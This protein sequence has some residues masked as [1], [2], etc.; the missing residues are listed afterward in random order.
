MP[1][2]VHWSAGSAS[3]VP[4]SFGKKAPPLCKSDCVSQLHGSEW[5]T[6]LYLQ[7]RKCRFVCLITMTAKGARCF[8]ENLC[9]CLNSPPTPCLS[10]FALVSKSEQWDEAE[11]AQSGRVG[12]WLWCEKQEWGLK[13][14]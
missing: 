2:F 1:V 8:L 12:R 6:H 7:G 11:V 13:M 5:D 9:G 4:T 14:P 3:M 10:V